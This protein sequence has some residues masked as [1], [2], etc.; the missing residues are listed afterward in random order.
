M[1]SF[2]IAT[3]TKTCCL[4]IIRCSTVIM[5]Y[6]N[7]CKSQNHKPPKKNIGEYLYDL[8]IGK[9]STLSYALTEKGKFINWT[10]SKLKTS[11]HQKIP[12]RNK[13]SKTEKKYLQYINLTKNSNPD[14]VINN[15]RQMAQ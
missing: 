5:Y 3:Q 12:I 4:C 6:S 13:K 7:K 10:S 1:D 2:F 11:I 14:Y 9:V 8:G 15:K